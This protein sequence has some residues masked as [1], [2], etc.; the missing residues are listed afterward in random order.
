M[1][2]AVHDLTAYLDHCRCGSVIVWPQLR[3]YGIQ[4]LQKRK[5]SQCYIPTDSAAEGVIR[6][7]QLQHSVLLLVQQ[8]YCNTCL[9]FLPVLEVDPGGHITNELNK[10]LLPRCDV[11]LH[12]E[13]PQVSRQHSG[14]RHKCRRIHWAGQCK[15]LNAA[16]GRAGLH[17]L[18]SSS[19]CP[20]DNRR[21]S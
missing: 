21:A 12:I 3:Q 2:R 11:E 1:Y 15:R 10:T 9:D 20:V 14:D 16:S 5:Q 19:C 13:H 8:M 18:R 4:P 6:K 17:L 7:K